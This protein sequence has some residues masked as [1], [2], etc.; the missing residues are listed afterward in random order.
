M[1]VVMPLGREKVTSDANF[2]VM[3]YGGCA[4]SYDNESEE[5]L[6]AVAR[7]RDDPSTCQ[8][9]CSYGTTNKSANLSLGSNSSEW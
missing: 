7:Y 6:T 4:C 9:Q 2:D 1:K 5:W 3:P 8:C